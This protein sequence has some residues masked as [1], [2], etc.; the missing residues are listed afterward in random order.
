MNRILKSRRMRLTG[1]VALMGGKE[2][3]LEKRR[4]RDF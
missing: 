4:A 1:Y 3:Y 2:E